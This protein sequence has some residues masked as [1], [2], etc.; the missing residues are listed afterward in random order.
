MKTMIEKISENRMNG[1]EFVVSKELAEDMFYNSI[2]NSLGYINEY[3]IELKYT[4]RDYLEAK[5]VL[6]KDG[7]NVCFEDVIMQIL[8]NGKTITFIDN[9]ECEDAVT[10]TLDII[11]QNIIYVPQKFLIDFLQENDDAETGDVIIQSIL[12]K[13]IVFG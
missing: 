3:G 6:I 8:R 2:C 4:K 9:E 11:H 10:L 7:S 13:E 5:E 12:Y 1:V